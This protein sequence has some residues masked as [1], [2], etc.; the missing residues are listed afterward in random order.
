MSP[1][2]EE[3]LLIPLEDY[4]KAGVH[5]GTSSGMRPMQEYIYRVRNDGLFVLDVRKT[6]ERIK[7]AAK[8]IARHNPSEIVVASVRTYGMYPVIQFAAITGCSSLTGRFVPGSFTNPNL[9]GEFTYHEPKLLIITDPNT[10]RQ[11]LKEANMVGI[12]VISLADTDNTT[13][14]IDFVIPCNNK[15]RNSLAT[16]FWLMAR[17]TL[18][19]RGE[20]TPEMDQNI[21]IDNFRAPRGKKRVSE[22]DLGL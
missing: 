2:E 14:G 10:D 18:R 6:D 4:L 12:P 16:V 7:I 11:A 19:E 8:F 17:E 5:I 1:E 22:S 9:K 15:G 3:N 20:L 13:Q 21:I